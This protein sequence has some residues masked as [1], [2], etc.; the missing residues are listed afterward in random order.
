MRG[1]IDVS[2][3][4]FVCFVCAVTRHTQGMQAILSGV[5]YTP[6]AAKLLCPKLSET[7]VQQLA[8][9]RLPYK[10]LGA[11]V[12]SSQ[13]ALLLSCCSEQQQARPITA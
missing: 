10:F 9:L 8:A 2:F 1:V 12:L 7:S 6:G 4:C 5:E 3:V 13:Q 11:Y